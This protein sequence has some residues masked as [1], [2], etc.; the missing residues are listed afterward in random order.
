M[1]DVY[2]TITDTSFQKDVL[3][4][5]NP[6]IVDFWAEWCGP[7][8]M[9]APIFED[10]AQEY[11]GKMTFTKLNTD[12]NPNTMMRYG[13]QGIP[14]LLFFHKGQMVEQLVGA[15]PRKDLKQHIDQ[16]LAGAA[17]KV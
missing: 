15:R 8:R 12:E 7:C 3:E 1:S 6:V 10:L 11:A 5:E 9:M 17:Q 13:I 16:V 4:S 14:T 2:T